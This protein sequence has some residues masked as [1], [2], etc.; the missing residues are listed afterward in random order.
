MNKLFLP[1]NCLLLS[2]F[3]VVIFFIVACQKEP[4]IQRSQPLAQDRLIQV[5]FNHNQAQGADYQEPYRQITR[6][7]DNLEKI[8][9]DEVNSAKSKIDVAV[10]EFRLP[11][12]ALAL[13]KRYQAGVKVRIIL[14]NN[15]SRPWSELTAE[16]VNQLED[17]ERDRYQDFFAFVDTNQ[18][19][20]LS[21][22]EI[23]KR[24]ALIILRNAKI[25]IIDDTEDG[26]K[27]TGLMHHKFI[28]VDDSTIITTSANLTLS[29]VH[30][31][32]RNPE[33]R[34]NANNLLRIESPQLAN[35]F[36]DEFKLM[37]GDGM[38][39]KQDS[40]FGTDKPFRQPQTLKLGNAK[41]TVRFSPTPATAPWNLTSNGLIGET[42]NESKNSVDLALFVFSDQRL[43]NILDKRHQQEV[44]VRALIDPEFA[45]R[46]Y[47]EALDMLGVAL[48]DNCR[49][50]KEN[51]PWK[52]PIDTV[53]IP[54][55]PIGDKLHHKFGIVDQDK[56]ITGS[57]N[58]SQAANS[59]N[60][61]TLLVIQSPTITAHFAR[62][63]ERLYGNAILGLPQELQAQVQQD[64]EKCSSSN[65]QPP[66]SQKPQLINLNTAS[67]EELE[68]L[69]GIGEKL[70]ERI[71]AARQ[72][73][74]F[75]SLED[76]DKVSGIGANTIKQLQG[77]V[78]W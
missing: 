47:S 74:L 28:I 53:V 37:W 15:Y 5:Y 55:L 48:S 24:D 19:G 70:A 58:W 14:E 63:F 1:F 17:R 3:F 35:L 10:Q 13:T 6:P 51:Q 56:V 34:G 52:M 45:Y 41:I 4:Q 54:R 16:E 30:S 61:E 50:E 31:D 65:S 60:D 32:F 69:P 22:Q 43:A 49:Y 26:S 23:N 77:K 8:M 18:D 27:G 2:C 38:G 75:T 64:S 25:P 62:E 36:R 71:I 7:G 73:K 57:H 76:L 72:E 68:T 9:I 12:L 39:G 78:T 66:S 40:Q 33:T 67:K 20:K 29:D 42:L 11:N 46:T 21:Q 59:L 44:N